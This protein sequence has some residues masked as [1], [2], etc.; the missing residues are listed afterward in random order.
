MFWR[1][2]GVA[3]GSAAVES[4][5]LADLDNLTIAATAILLARY[6]F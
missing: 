2:A 5:P 1:I 4:L 6:L 3:L